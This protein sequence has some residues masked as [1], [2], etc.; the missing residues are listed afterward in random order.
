VLLLA[1]HR[2]MEQTGP[3]ASGN[4]YELGGGRANQLAD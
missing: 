2:D 4:Q 1:K 3:Q